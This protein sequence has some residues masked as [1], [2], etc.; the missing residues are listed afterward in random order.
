MSDIE[1]R[2][3]KLQGHALC[4][5]VASPQWS[6]L[7]VKQVI[8]ERLQIS[9]YCQQLVLGGCIV[10][11][12][13]LV[14]TSCKALLEFSGGADVTL[15]VTNQPLLEDLF[16]QIP[17]TEIPEPCESREPLIGETVYWGRKRPSDAPRF[18]HCEA[19]FV[20][21]VRP[22]VSFEDDDEEE[23]EEQDTDFEFRLRRSGGE[24]VEDW[25]LCSG[26]F[27]R[28]A[29]DQSLAGMEELG[30]LGRAVPTAVLPLVCDQLSSRNEAGMDTARQGEGEESEVTEDKTLSLAS[31]RLAAART[32]R[33]CAPDINSG[34]VDA[35]ITTCVAD[36]DFRVRCAA[37]EAL[38]DITLKSSD[39]GVDHLFEVMAKLRSAGEPQ[40]LTSE[41][42][43]VLG[44]L[45]ENAEVREVLARLRG[46]HVQTSVG[47]NELGGRLSHLEPQPGIDFD[48]GGTEFRQKA[49]SPLNRILSLS[50]Y[51]E[52]SL[53]ASCVT[54]ELRRMRLLCKSLRSQCKRELFAR[55]YQ[56]QVMSDARI[57]ELHAQRECWQKTRV[58]LTFQQAQ[59]LDIELAT[60]FSFVR[61]HREELQ[62]QRL[63]DLA[64][65][66]ASI[67]LLGRLDPE[68]FTEFILET[69]IPQSDAQYAAINWEI[70]RLIGLTDRWWV[71]S[72]GGD[73]TER[74]TVLEAV[75]AA[76][77]HGRHS[78]WGASGV[79]EEHIYRL[80]EFTFAVEGL[81]HTF[82]HEMEFFVARYSM[83][84]YALQ[85]SPVARRA[86]RFCF[87]KHPGSLGMCFASELPNYNYGGMGD[88]VHRLL[89][90]RQRC[91]VGDIIESDALR[92][93]VELRSL[94]VSH[95][96]W[97]SIKYPAVVVGG[98]GGRN[99]TI[100]FPRPHSKVSDWNGQAI[101]VFR[102]I[103]SGSKRLLNKVTSSGDL[104]DR[105]ALQISSVLIDTPGLLRELVRCHERR[106]LEKLIRVAPHFKDLA[107]VR[108]LFFFSRSVCGKQE[109]ITEL[110]RTLRFFLMWRAGKEHSH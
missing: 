21:D 106:T 64:S 103:P 38:V 28:V 107:I 75:F 37:A 98:H 2:V 51:T 15:V 105:F 101:S 24:D 46:L 3:S 25:T 32:L 91:N 88:Y 59:A 56:E 77:A 99:T 78:W 10:D 6:W 68:V 20:M 57:K 85:S 14:I 31:V 96:W 44:Q 12:R 79:G 100:H 23:E 62:A 81:S 52:V 60:S 108:P 69:Y 41:A 27:Y 54:A 22:L 17:C 95:S 7:D 66:G 84:L 40:G 48:V 82:C 80:L 63:L 9:A 35:L 34:V 73:A 29:P 76:F 65:Q 39:E 33:F 70:L 49:D 72:S 61:T 102:R 30:R 13:S 83:S 18:F 74:I 43:M 67:C 104:R 42:N 89:V 26:F 19:A 36:D 93:M 110:L 4:A 86:L 109:R 5:V 71:T 1:L 45:A 47:A 90:D 58:A 55:L 11:D 8:A 16:K 92:V 94:G 50:T 97:D 53:L 87:W